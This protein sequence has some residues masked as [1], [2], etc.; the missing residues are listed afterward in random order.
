MKIKTFETILIG[1]NYDIPARDATATWS[2]VYSVIVKLETDDGVLGF[3]E[4]EV[5]RQDE[6][7]IYQSILE[8]RFKKYIIGAHISESQN[9]LD[10]ALSRD[11]GTSPMIGAFARAAAAVDMAI[12]DLIGKKMNMPIYKLWNENAISRP[13]RAYASGFFEV[14]NSS[15]S[16]KDVAKEAETYV[17][18]GF[19]A[20]KIK[21]GFDIEKDMKVVQ[22][23][24]D[25][26]GDKIDLMVDANQVYS[27]ETALKVGKKLDSLDVF[28]FEEPISAY[29]FDGLKQLKKNLQVKIAGGESYWTVRD[30]ENVIKN[31]ILDIIQ[32]DVINIGGLTEA[33]KIVALT[34]EYDF[35]FAP[36]IF[37]TLN[38]AASIQLSTSSPNS[39]II[40]YIMGDGVWKHRDE[41]FIETIKLKNGYVNVSDQPGLGVQINE[42]K[43]E[44]Y[45]LIKNQ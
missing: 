9:I 7:E 42:E 43:L 26:V 27:V 3:G 24:R 44:K 38:L 17:R 18:L 23:I 31:S 12:L 20:M 45:K 11:S 36:H 15:R 1:S 34:E 33:R 25:V 10:K 30:F 39:E 14:L 22:T 40:E 16:L 37:S 5:Y 2:G 41:I 32:I 8:N 21:I 29:N 35:P 4:V 28:W 13:L 19:T 6:I